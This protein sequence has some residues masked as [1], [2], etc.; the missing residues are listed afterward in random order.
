MALTPVIFYK[1]FTLVTYGPSKTSCY[2]AIFKNVLAHFA[3]S[4]S[5]KRK[6][7]MKLTPDRFEVSVSAKAD[8][9]GVEGVISG[10]ESP[11]VNELVLLA[12][13]D[14]EVAG[15]LAAWGQLFENLFFVTDEEK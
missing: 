13:E 2:H 4:V 9:S 7:F 14:V 3:L 12:D 8:D 5:Y 15:R 10:L 11:D 6:M 1:H